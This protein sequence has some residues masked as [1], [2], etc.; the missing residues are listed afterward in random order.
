MV[1]K[2]GDKVL[3]F[4]QARGIIAGTTTTEGSIRYVVDIG[5]GN[6]DQ[7]IT[8]DGCRMFV[9]YVVCDPSSLEHL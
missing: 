9:S 8:K 1:G 6:D 4:G 7:Y 2:I 5:Y 3:I